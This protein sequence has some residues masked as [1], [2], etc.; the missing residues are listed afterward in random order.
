MTQISASE[1]DE[2]LILL[3][4]RIAKL[5]KL[6]ADV[7]AKAV[8]DFRSIREGASAEQQSGLICQ[9]LYRALE[10]LDGKP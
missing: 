1:S 9:G 2:K 8:F 4:Y 7:R 10:I 3:E 5:R 6:E